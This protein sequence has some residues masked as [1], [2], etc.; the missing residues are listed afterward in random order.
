MALNLAQAD[1]MVAA[2][3]AADVILKVYEN[4]IF[5]PPVQRAKALH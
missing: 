5:Y 2:A 4:F 1:E 3:H